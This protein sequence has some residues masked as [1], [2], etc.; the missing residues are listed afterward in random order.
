MLHA[1]SLP[2][3]NK[4]TQPTALT[5]FAQPLIFAS[6]AYISRLDDELH[7]VTRAQ[8]DGV[9]RLGKVEEDLLHHIGTL[10]KPERVLHRADHPAVLHRMGRI[11]QPDM[12]G[13]QVA[14]TR[15]NKNP[16]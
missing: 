13:S 1:T 14:P 9:V 12:T 15:K 2:C 16:V 4:Q 7:V 10:N 3:L 5:L 11:L 6:N 8:L